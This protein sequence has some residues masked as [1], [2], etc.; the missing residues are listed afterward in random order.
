MI[1]TSKKDRFLAVFFYKQLKIRQCK[2]KKTPLKNKR[3]FVGPQ[4]LEP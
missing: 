4:G 2:N 3:S 1:F